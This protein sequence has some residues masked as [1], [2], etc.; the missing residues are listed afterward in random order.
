MY[1]NATKDKVTEAG[2][3]M[4]VLIYGG[5]RN[6]LSDLRYINHK[7]L[8]AT[9]QKLLPEKL[10]PYEAAAKYHCWRVH[11]QVKKT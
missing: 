8:A 2:C 11:I 3:L 10:F 6:R 9:T 4:F 1:E 7:I 5:G